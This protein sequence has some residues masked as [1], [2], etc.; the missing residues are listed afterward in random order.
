[1]RMRGRRHTVGRDRRAV[2]H[3]YDLP[4]D[5]YRLLLGPSMTYSCALWEDEGYT[6]EDAQRAKH[7]LVAR[8]LA[9]GSG[10][11]LLD[12][13]CGWGG[14]VEHA[15]CRHGVRAVGVTLSAPQQEWATRR[16]AAAGAGEAAEIRVQD[17]RAVDDGPYD[18]ISSIGMSEHVGDARL[19]GYFARLYTLLRPGGR[20]LNHAISSIPALH[21]SGRWP[22]W[23]PHPRRRHAA[24]FGEAT[25]ISRYV[26]PDGE[27][28]EVGRVVSAMQRAGF[29]VRHVET[30]R[31]HYPL[32]LRRWLA[33][34]DAAWPEA[35]ALVG[36]RRARAWR[37]YLA[38]SVFSFEV[39]RI[40]VHQVLA[41]RP[42]AGSSGTSLR[43]AF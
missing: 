7:E 14:M 4:G 13:G 35:A 20:L 2:T 39:G 24:R 8:K 21:V 9:L 26:F 43:P 41:V 22:A 15:V 10:L 38:G 1:V 6:L 29:E 30:L 31:E 5:F 11:R 23:A 27:L 28:V 16:L 42:G 12:V 25:F 37:L 18:A 36:A 33:N 17:Y 40:G 32:T 19:P 3:H 34:L